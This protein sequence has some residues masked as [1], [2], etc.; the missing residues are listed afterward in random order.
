M[1][2]LI[3]LKGCLSAVK[4]TRVSLNAFHFKFKH[5]SDRVRG[6]KLL[7]GWII[8]GARRRRGG[9][10]RREWARSRPRRSVGEIDDVTNERR[11]GW[12]AACPF[13]VPTPSLVHYSSL[14]KK[15]QDV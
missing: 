15:Q 5:R 4:M 6:L 2:P 13:S 14:D 1:G 11:L 8:S 7:R 10:K 3:G 12:A 9:R